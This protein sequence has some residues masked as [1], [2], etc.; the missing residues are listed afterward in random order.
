MIARINKPK[1]KNKKAK[2]PSCKCECKLDCIKCNLNQKWNNDKY[3]C[4]WKYPK[5][6]NTCAKDCIWNHDVCTCKNGKYIA[7]II[8]D[9]VIMCDD[10]IE[11]TKTVPTNSNRIETVPTKITSINIYILLDISL[12]TIALLIAV[13]AYCCFIKYW[14]KQKRLSPYCLTNNK[15]K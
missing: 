7:S 4:V 5:K 10:I 3:R 15:L 2:H 1:T 6:D 13:S 9:S 14:A 12:I 8:D 11:E